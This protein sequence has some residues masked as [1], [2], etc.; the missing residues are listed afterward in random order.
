MFDF[1][2]MPFHFR[3]ALINNSLIE[4]PANGGKMITFIRFSVE[5]VE[6]QFHT[7]FIGI[8]SSTRF[9]EKKNFSFADTFREVWFAKW[10]QLT[11]IA[12]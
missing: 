1:F 9:S 7:L 4:Q 8:R 2:F 3:Y 12:A 6:W 5:N 10:Q 11:E